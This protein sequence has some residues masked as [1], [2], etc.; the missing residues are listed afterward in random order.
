[1]AQ[2]NNL[3]VGGNNNN[4]SGFARDTGGS[5]FV[6]GSINPTTGAVIPASRAQANDA[7]PVATTLAA[8][9]PPPPPAP[10]GPNLG[11]VAGGYVGGAVGGS[12]GSQIGNGASVASAVG[13]TGANIG[14]VLKTPLGLG[15]SSA[16]AA[17][18]VAPLG[19]ASSSDAID[20]GGFTPG[21]APLNLASVAAAPAPTLLN[22]ASLADA[23]SGAVSAGSVGGSI[24]AGLG[25]GV[26]S[27]VAGAA[28]APG[29]FV[30]NLGK[31]S[32]YIPAAEEAIG[33]G[34]GYFIGGIVGGPIG[35][36]IGGA[37][38]GGIA[39]LFCHAAGTLIRMADG[40]VRAIE[41]LKIGDDV[42][43]GGK[44]IG[45]GEVLS[46]DLYHYKNTVVN[47]RHAVLEAGQWVRVQD[48]PACIVSSPEA[49]LVYPIVTERHLLVCGENY[50]C[51]DFAETDDADM[52]ASARL[53]RLNAMV[54]R[55]AYLAE[56][57]EFMFLRSQWTA[58]ELRRFAAA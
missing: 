22:G 17:P 1:M 29:S 27:E 20:L 41:E 14:N 38:G 37:I 35:A 42:L 54:E 16:P 24:G 52:S 34:A 26:I 46:A 58:D 51:A 5:Q 21:N 18:A 19:S 25:A 28:E 23:A 3:N 44:V 13:N 6:G 10:S 43:L 40:T 30:K 9:Q 53:E 8:V 47:G 55:N 57:W 56:F 12:I 33:T 11:S 39:S 45:R 7:P 48:T 50:I 49:Q 4:P 32:V 31:P 36:A 15:S 2:E